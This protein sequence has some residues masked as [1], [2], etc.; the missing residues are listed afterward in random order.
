MKTMTK[1]KQRELDRERELKSLEWR[2]E[3]EDFVQNWAFVP[4]RPFNVKRGICGDYLQQRTETAWEVWCGARG[5][6]GLC[7]YG[8]DP[9]GNVNWGKDKLKEVK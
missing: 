2:K 1:R 9:K 6:H 3:F 4:R 8:I 7:T 5:D